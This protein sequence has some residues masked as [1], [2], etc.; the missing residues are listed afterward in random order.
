M[1]DPLLRVAAASTYRS[2]PHA[3]LTIQRSPVRWLIEG[4]MKRIATPMRRS[5][6][7]LGPEAWNR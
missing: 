1:P 5:P 6:V 7:L 4:L 2:S 3:N